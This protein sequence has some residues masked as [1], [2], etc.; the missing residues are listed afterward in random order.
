MNHKFSIALAGLTLAATSFAQT[1]WDLPTAYPSPRVP[2]RPTDFAIFSNSL[3]ISL[4]A[5][6][7][8]SVIS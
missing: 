3:A 7:K 1:K 5:R 4:F 6:P 2:G 8:M